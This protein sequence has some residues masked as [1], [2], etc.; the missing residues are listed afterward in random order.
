MRSTSLTALLIFFVVFLFLTTEV[1]EMTAAAVPDVECDDEESKEE[2]P[3]AFQSS[4]W[5]LTD[6]G[7]GG[8]S[9]VANQVR[10]FL[11]PLLTDDETVPEA[12]DFCPQLA[13]A[14]A[15]RSMDVLVA[16]T[17]D[18][19]SREEPCPIVDDDDDDEGVMI[20]GTWPTVLL[21]H[22]EETTVAV[23]AS[24][25]ADVVFSFDVALSGDNL[26][27][28]LELLLARRELNDGRQLSPA[29]KALQKG[30]SDGGGT[31]NDGA[32]ADDAATAPLWV[33]GVVG[34]LIVVGLVGAV[35]YVL[36]SNRV[37]T[38]RRKR[39][40]ADA[41]NAADRPSSDTEVS[42][43]TPRQPPPPLV[44]HRKKAVGGPMT[45]E[46]FM[47]SLA[48]I[49]DYAVR[50]RDTVESRVVSSSVSPG[51]LRSRLP[52]EAPQTPDTIAVIL[53]DIETHIMPGVR[54]ILFLTHFHP[55]PPVLCS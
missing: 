7:G 4:V 40:D 20:N 29:F 34:A 17:D 22:V 30:N 42:M 43:T 23:L 28:A 25:T 55:N 15:N 52:H 47:Q 1:R 46:Q 27:G 44:V 38:R 2:V 6:G 39:R 33:V 51:Y 41:E 45:P 49:A 26:R 16:V 48:L 11:Y 36:A 14:V 9:K 10:C 3:A 8:S 53:Q 24:I 35:I 13:V 5:L 12:A 18:S 31:N 19:S 32:G 50:Y 37:R 21:L 54:L